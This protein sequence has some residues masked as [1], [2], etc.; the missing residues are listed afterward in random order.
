M[1]SMRLLR[2]VHHAALAAVLLAP[3][4]HAQGKFDLSLAN[5]MRGPEV[6]GREPARV[7][8]S[9]DGQWIY[10]AWNPPGTDWRE[11]L[12]PYRVRAAAGA[13]PERLT[14][15]QMDSAGPLITDGPLSPDRKLR[16][17]DFRGDIYLL[18][19]KK[20]TSR[21]LSRTLLFETNPTWS[22]DG[23]RVFYTREG[24]AWSI[25]ISSGSVVQLTDIRTGPAPD[26]T[27][28]TSPQ[29]AALEKD[30]RLLLQAIRDK[31][32]ADSITK[33]E[34]KRVE[35]LLPATVWLQA[36]E[37]V[38][39]LEVSPAGTAAIIVTNRAATDAKNA[40]VPNYVTGSG[41]TEEIDARTK[42]GDAQSVSRVGVITLPAGT[43]KWINALGGDSLPPAFLTSLGWNEAGTSAL[44]TATSRDYERRVLTRV[45]ANGTTA[46]LDRLRDTAWVGGPC[47][48]CAGWYD[49]GA[50]AWFVSEATGYAQLWSVAADGSDH[51]ALTTGNFEVERVQLS[52]DKR[53]FYLH[54]SEGSPYERH[55]FRMLTS[56][57]VRE[58]LT[59]GVGSHAGVMSPDES[60][61]ADVFSS[62]NRPP[63]LF[64]ASVCPPLAKCK[65]MPPAQL[66]TSPTA[67]W[68]AHGWIDPA[69]VEISAS[70]G[71]KVPARIYRPEDVGA[72]PNGA[73]VIF[74]HGAGYLHNVHKFWSSYSRE[75][76]F[77]HLLASKG[78]V[79]L[80]LDYRA[81]A[82][83]GRDWRTA[84]YRW[85]G[86]RD[87]QDQVDASKWLGATY[88][89]H[90]ERIGM[91]G[92]SYGGFITLMAL[93]TAPKSFGAGA[94]LR[95]VT[96][97]AH[98][99][100]PY[101][102][103]ILNLP[104]DDSVAYRRS[105]P[106]FLAEGLEDPLL[107]AHGMVDV[108]VHYEDSA[109]LA[110]RLIELGKGDW[111][112]A[113]YPVEDH[114]FVRPT[115][116]TDEYRR[117]LELFER[118]IGPNGSKANR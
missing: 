72:K 14:E 107:I 64:L 118:T 67:E 66:T 88:G 68:L 97:W 7:R 74:V 50:R 6:Y 30:Q 71:V 42:V 27:A 55:W 86:G 94:A 113:S 21:R 48:G 38:T 31:D 61:Y 51:R 90:P 77:N 96:D 5:I 89:V 9:A 43:V 114:G 81:S 28:R 44:V 63:E 82:G 76:M 91:Y 65:M 84:I 46:V 70:D 36:R 117:I 69:I 32:R 111:E 57:G 10:F 87:L 29:R 34:R 13:T 105:S 47:S 35:A 103:Q 45:D 40:Q 53:F 80:D 23:G 100:H 19:T 116:W 73:A 95:P 102:G 110:Q 52:Q 18:D 62:S 4:A 58:R 99:N 16:V 106:I 49:G 41:Y 101:T 104:Q 83:Y 75:Y 56:G 20:G 109:R 54:T 112:L 39:Q 25:D 2:S 24:N 1:T 60:R 12:A 15:V 78:Y 26:T 3:A 33:A 115:S 85:M 98:Y 108:N 92:G 11:A 8:W 79:V 17:V 59:T 37:R 22:A 93:F